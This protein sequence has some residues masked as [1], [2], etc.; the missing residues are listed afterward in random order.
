MTQKIIGM[1]EVPPGSTVTVE[2][3]LLCFFPDFKDKLRPGLHFKLVEG[4]RTVA[5]GVVE[6]FV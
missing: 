3:Q 1:D 6:G 2:A 4:N 5:T